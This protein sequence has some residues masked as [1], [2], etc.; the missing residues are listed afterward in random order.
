MLRRGLGILAALAALTGAA[1]AL[2]K[3]ARAE[4]YLSGS[5]GYLDLGKL[6]V[7]R[8]GFSGDAEFE[9]SYLLNGALGYRFHLP[10]F[11]LRLEV[12]GGYGQAEVS[13]VSVTTPTGASQTGIVRGGNSDL[14]TA[15]FNGFVDFPVTPLLSPYIGA[16]VGAAHSPTFPTSPRR[17]EMSR[18]EAAARQLS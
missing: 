3:P 8:S 11:N 9:S 12:E 2:A 7:T 17:T 10:G 6:Q 1:L 16:G 15:T 13:S 5:G 18:S 4:F 14:Y